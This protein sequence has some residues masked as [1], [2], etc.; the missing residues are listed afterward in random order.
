MPESVIPP[1]REPLTT[2]AWPP[3]RSLSLNQKVKEP[4]GLNEIDSRRM[5][6]KNWALVTLGKAVRSVGGPRVG[7]RERGLVTFGVQ[8]FG[9]LEVDI[10]GSVV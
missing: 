6:F 4:S 1:L 5:R 9:G 7:A 10:W 2:T 8:V 3:K